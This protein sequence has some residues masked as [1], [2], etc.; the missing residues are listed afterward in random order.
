MNWSKKNIYITICLIF[1]L[2]IFV[3]CFSLFNKTKDQYTQLKIIYRTLY[4]FHPQPKKVNDAFSKRVFFKYFDNLD[5]MKV[6]FYK[7]DIDFFSSYKKKLDDA[8]IN[9]DITF[10]KKTIN[11][12]YKRIEY[13]EKLYEELLNI[14]FNFNLYETVI[15]NKKSFSYPNNIKEWKNRIRLYLKYL[16]IIEMD[17]I[18]NHEDKF[19]IL[20]RYLLLNNYKHHKINNSIIN[21]SLIFLEKNARIKV[22]EN[23]RKYFKKIKIKKKSDLF[24]LYIN[25]NTSQYDPHTLFLS[26]QEKLN[27]NLDLS[28]EIEGVGVQ[29]QDINGYPTITKIVEGSPAWKSKKIAIGDKIIK[30]SINNDEKKDKNIVGMPL[31]DSIQYIRGKK[32]TKVHLTIQKKDGTKKRVSL[33]RKLIE[34][35][36]IFV[37]SLVISDKNKNKYGLIRLPEFYFNPNDKKAR[38]S[39]DDIKNELEYLKKENISGVILDLRNN[40]GGSLQSVINIVGFFI[41][42]GPVAQLLRN[43]GRKQI[44]LSKSNNI[45]WKGPLIIIVNE[46]SASA[47]EILASAIKDYNRG[48]IIGSNKTFGKGTIQALYPLNK[49]LGMIKITI[50][51]FYRINGKSTQ[52]KGINSDII[53]PSNYIN[54]NIKREENLYNPLPWDKISPIFYKPWRDFNLKK[55]IYKSNYR[56]KNNKN[57]NLL[58][59]AIYN[60]NKNKNFIYLNLKDFFLEK[61]N[62]NKILKNIFILNIKSNIL[63]PSLNFNNYIFNIQNINKWYNNIYTDLCIK[64]S[65]RIFNDFY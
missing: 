47:S 59:N 62:Y 10:F 7:K 33:I 30:V 49:K 16:T 17:S 65:I 31:N 64:E 14:P 2:L 15:F 58:K 37:K 21:E 3:V 60:I 5:P 44:L 11:Y 12:F 63:Y 25:A 35:E 48:I 41:G 54:Y 39:S 4:F 34:K 1:F 51:K 50:G 19:F 24:S 6:I 52:L 8:F 29:I 40:S 45:I 36:E 9:G 57:I 18:L 22:L 53:I 26:E 20:K 38:N 55:I 42:K 13:L 32:G 28:G 43:D 61:K 27:F 46:L 23:M 56:I